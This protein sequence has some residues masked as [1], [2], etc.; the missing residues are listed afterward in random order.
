MPAGDEI[1]QFDRIAQR[2]QSLRDALR[3]V[4][5][6]QDDIVEQLLVS[7]F[8]Q[9]HALI[10]GVPGLAKTLLVRTLAAAL[11]L[12]FHRIQFT[13]DMMPSDILGTELIQEDATTGRRSLRFVPGPVFAQLILA[14]E[15]NR[16][17]PKTQAAL[18]EAM[19]ER[20][21]T[22]AGRTAPMERPFIVVAT[23]NPIEQEG[24]YPLPEAQLDRFM[25]SLWM[26][27]PSKAQEKQ[28]VAE[29]ARIMAEQVDPVFTRDDLLEAAGLICRMPV[30][31]HVVDYAVSLARATRPAD[32]DAPE[33]CRQY[34]EWGAGPRAGQHL[35]HGAQALAAMAGR[36]T[37]GC[38]DVARLAMAVLR[39]RVLV[40]YAATGEGI[41]S[42]DVIAHLLEAIEQPSYEPG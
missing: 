37:P 6:G 34:V 35:V 12:S 28:V 9:G 27:Y 26:D 41:T 1:E 14:D 17:P 21:V 5:V 31:D 42:A 36:P 30:S 4:I 2:C 15:V 22:V 3:R 38:D 8:C 25:F 19:A 39:H 16:T 13:P 24:T 32:P 11:D 10:V 18:L 40:N 23:Q 20:Q 7:V 29:T 33:I